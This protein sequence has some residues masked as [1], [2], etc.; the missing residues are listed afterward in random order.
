MAADEYLKVAAGQLQQAATAVKMS[1]DQIRADAASF[2]M[3]AEREIAS[4]T[5]ELQ[6]RKNE[7]H[8]HVDEPATVAATTMLIDK[9]Q[10]EIDAIKQ[11]L[12]QKTAQA[13]QAARSKEGAMQGLSS[14]A[15]KLQ[16]QAG[17]PNLR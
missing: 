9:L 12:T 14:Q 10:K 7:L 11:D 16:Q 17:D 4:K 8:R 6:V 2:K 15:Q 13:E 3:Q 1:A 5:S